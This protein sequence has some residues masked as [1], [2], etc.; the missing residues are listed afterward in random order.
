MHIPL[1]VI[2]EIAVDSIISIG[3]KGIVSR[4]NPAAEKLFGYSSDEALYNAKGHG[5]NRIEVSNLE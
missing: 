2:L 3:R 1:E 5:R 4:F